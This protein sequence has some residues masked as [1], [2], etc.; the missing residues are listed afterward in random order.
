V[1]SL[2]FAHQYNQLH[3]AV[4]TTPWFSI[5]TN[6]PLVVGEGKAKR[7][8]PKGGYPAAGAN[9]TRVVQPYWS[10][11]LKNFPNMDLEVVLKDTHGCATFGTCKPD[12]VGYLANKPQSIFHIAL[13]GDVKARRQANEDGFNT[14]KKGQLADVLKD[15]LLDFQPY[16]RFVDG[17]LTDG[18]LIQFFRLEANRLEELSPACEL[19]WMEGPVLRL[20]S[21]GGMWL[22]GFLQDSTVHEL[23][24]DIVI[25]KEPVVMNQLLGV[26]GSSVVFRGT[27][28]GETTLSFLVLMC[29]VFFPLGSLTSTHSHLRPTTT[30]AEV[31]VKRFNSR[32]LVENLEREAA[33]L[34]KIQSAVPRV[35]RLIACDWQ[36][37]V[38]LLQPVGVQFAS[39]VSHF[40]TVRGLHP[41][42]SCHKL[43]PEGRTHM[44]IHDDTNFVCG[45]AC[46]CACAV[47]RVRVRLCV[48]VCLQNKQL[49]VATADDFC[50][51]VSI[52]Q[53]VHRRFKL[54]HCDVRLPNV[55]RDPETGLVLLT[56]PTLDPPTLA[57]KLLVVLLLLTRAAKQ[58]ISCT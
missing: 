23:P 57:I 53:T 56:P 1:L 54:V 3:K 21:W 9:K 13:V 8:F 42:F 55:F 34:A 27:H 39:R 31:V 14:S 20:H 41:T 22:L 36:N 16:R 33:I 43:R 15:L 28:Q 6:H 30:G 4:V 35:P 32:R 5:A 2:S 25:N 17:F 51:L 7:L 47:V 49:A 38:I 12:V 29:V 48:C 45:C 37:L 52:L 24:E 18:C 44:H 50:Q 19:E 26:G 58:H 40:T 46:A 11:K 10:D